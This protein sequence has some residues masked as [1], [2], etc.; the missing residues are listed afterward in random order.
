M[1]SS[2]RGQMRRVEAGGAR[3]R[4][5]RGVARDLV[6]EQIARERV[7]RRVVER[8]RGDR[9]QDARVERG[10]ASTAGGRQLAEPVFL[11]V[12]GGERRPFVLGIGAW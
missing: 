8:V 11:A 1:S 12:R 3:E 2:A 5:V 4:G 7:E 6:R 10:C 9:R